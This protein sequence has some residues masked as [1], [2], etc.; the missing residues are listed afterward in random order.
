MNMVFPKR[1]LT[2]YEISYEIEER[3]SLDPRAG[4]S[5]Q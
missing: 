3:F 1:T 4:K 5:S 2:V